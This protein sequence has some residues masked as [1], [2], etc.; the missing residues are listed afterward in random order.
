MV[1]SKVKDCINSCGKQDDCS[2]MIVKTRISKMIVVVMK[3]I[4]VLL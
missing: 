3:M 4:N 2:K 1:V